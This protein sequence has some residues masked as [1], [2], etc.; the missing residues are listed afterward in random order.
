MKTILPA[1]MLLPLAVLVSACSYST[2]AGAQALQDTIAQQNKTIQNQQQMLADQEQHLRDQ[3][4]RMD[5]LTDELS[6]AQSAHA[7]ASQ[8]PVPDTGND[9]GNQT[10]T[11]IDTAKSSV[12]KTL[13][14]FNA[15]LSSSI[16][17]ASYA[18]ALS[19]LNSTLAQSLLNVKD[20]DFVDDVNKILHVYDVA[21]DFWERFERDQVDEITLTSTERYRYSS[22]GVTFVEDYAPRPTDVRKFFRVANT[23]LDNLMQVNKDDLGLPDWVATR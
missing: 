23:Q 17:Y 22:V 5:E 9:T 18:D 3:E 6:D 10:A 19:D 7:Q 12:V 20:Q 21:G 1:A 4:T 11:T 13:T 16:D 8:T 15:R 14:G 2:D